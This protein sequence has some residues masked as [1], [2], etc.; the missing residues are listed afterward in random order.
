MEELQRIVR[1]PQLARKAGV[2]G[3][4]TVR[5]YLDSTAKVRHAR[6][7]RGIGGGCDEEA[8]EVVKNVRFTPAMDKGKPVHVRIFIPV[9]FRLSKDKK[10]KKRTE[11]L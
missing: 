9:E 2:E 1:Y 6:V 5:V 3:V 11:E 10:V 8:V 4:V 7:E